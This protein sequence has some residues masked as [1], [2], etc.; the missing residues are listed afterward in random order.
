MESYLPYFFIHI[1]KNTAPVK[2][3]YILM[4]HHR[5]PTCAGGCL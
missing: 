2:S 1:F 4:P 3:M 5:V